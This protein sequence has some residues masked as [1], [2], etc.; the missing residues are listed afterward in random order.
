MKS[1]YE[2]NYGLEL[3]VGEAV[4]KVKQLWNRH[5]APLLHRTAQHSD[6]ARKSLRNMR[7]TLKE[8]SGLVDDIKGLI[9]HVANGGKDAEAEAAQKAKAEANKGWSTTHKVAAGVGATAGVGA[10]GY[11]AYRLGKGSNN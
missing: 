1:Y 4:G 10:L 3:D 9:S 2:F 6:D 5:G 7:Q 11:G 8:G